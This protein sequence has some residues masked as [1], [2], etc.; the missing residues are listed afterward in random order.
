VAASHRSRGLGSAGGLE[1]VFGDVAAD[2][3]SEGSAL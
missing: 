1:V 2:R 3:A